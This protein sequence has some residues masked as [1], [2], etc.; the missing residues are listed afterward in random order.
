MQVC[1]WNYHAELLS[2]PVPRYT[3]Y[4]TAA[5]FGDEVGQVDFSDA[6][7]T[8]T[9]DVSLY[10][11]IPFC[12]QICWYCGCN[13]AAANRATRLT[14]YLDALHKEIMLVAE[15]LPAGARVRRIAFGGGSPNA[16]NPVDFIRL[17]DQLTLK[18]PLDS[19]TV[20]IELDPRSLTQEWE[21]V[22]G[23]IGVSHAS[24]GVQ[25]FAPSLQ[26]AIGR[27]QPVAMIDRAVELLR[28]A[29]VGSLNLDL[30]YGLPGQNLDDVSSS[31]DMAQRLGAD[32]VAFFG[33]AHVPHL[34]PRQRQID[35]SNLPDQLLRFNMAALGYHNMVHAGYVPVGFDHFALPG[36]S[37]ARAATAG[38]LHRN[39]QGFTDDSAT[40][41]IGLGASAISSFPNLLAQHE[42][43]AGRYRM[44]LSQGKAPVARGKVRTVEDRRR[45]AII[46]EL[47]CQGRARVDHAIME[48][49]QDRL[50]PFARAGLFEFAG[51]MFVIPESSLPYARSIAA[52]FDPYRQDSARRFSSAV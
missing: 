13:T 7:S 29:G 15:M 4:P 20:A 18:F 26:R 5:E 17:M 1:M 14:S 12:D 34:I 9:G 16:I 51:G 21:G 27:I 25:T 10:V 44:L 49:A 42:K 45:G 31:L 6:V 8:A 22:L 41:L 19:P 35:G 43:N 32:R 24:L 50:E 33:Y 38:E 28:K 40:T 39:F 11:N 48:G 47:L 37:L 30:M 2:S 23:A 3:S 36:D 46:E 52:C